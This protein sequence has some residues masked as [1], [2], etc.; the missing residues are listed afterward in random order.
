MTKS[1]PFTLR[2][3]RGTGWVLSAAVLTMLYLFAAAVTPAE[4]ATSEPHAA[5]ASCFQTA[6]FPNGSAVVGMAVTPDDG[7]YWVADNDGYVAACGDAAY[8]GEQ[9]TL[10]API[11]GIAATPD[12]GGYYLVASDGG[13]FAFGDAQFQGSTGSIKLNRPVVG[14]DG[15][16]GHGRLSAG[17]V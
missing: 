5:G 10:N 7:G 12:G 11:V 16:S 6:G 14:H 1:A 8:L 17:C 4:S 9:T 13:I 3:M 2:S 15:R